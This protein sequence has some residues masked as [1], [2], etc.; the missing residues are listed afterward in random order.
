VE[1]V[2]H[3]KN[4]LAVDEDV[5]IRDVNALGGGQSSF[6]GAVRVHRRGLDQAGRRDHPRQ[7]QSGTS[8]QHRRDRRHPRPRGD[9]LGRGGT[10]SSRS[11][12]ATATAFT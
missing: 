8:L 1:V 6:P 3:D 7:H 12:R 9:R 5:N 2:T 10:S 4:S 11:D